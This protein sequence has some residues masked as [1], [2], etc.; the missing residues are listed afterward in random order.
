MKL[1][2]LKPLWGRGTPELQHGIIVEAL[3]G[4]S[5]LHTALSTQCCL[6]WQVL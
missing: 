4:N 2:N 1:K 6:R 5:R 3:S